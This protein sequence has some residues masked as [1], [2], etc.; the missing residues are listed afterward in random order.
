MGD[1][2]A[3]DGRRLAFG[4]GPQKDRGETVVAMRLSIVMGS[5]RRKALFSRGR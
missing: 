2:P 3:R 4:T 1:D 5:V